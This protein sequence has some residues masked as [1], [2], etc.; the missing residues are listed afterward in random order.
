MNTNNKAVITCDLVNSS[1]YSSHERQSVNERI[2]QFSNKWQK[3]KQA[4]Y[5]FYRGDSL[6]GILEN[7]SEALRQALY[8]KSIIKSISLETSKRSTEADI[9]IS[10]GIGTIDYTGN[11]LLD[12][13][14]PAFQYS[15]RTLDTLKQKGRTIALTTSDSKQNK[16][17]DT[18]LLL[19]E[20][21]IKHWTI[22]SAEIIWRLIDGWSDKEIQKDLKI[23]Q[24]AVSQRKKNASWE[25]IEKTIL[26]YEE[27]FKKS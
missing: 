13:D 25:A 15:G 19:L 14:G 23:S 24:P 10:I 17:W 18:I 1:K 16:V 2:I 11:T 21:V 3:G 8:L 5:L 9:R 27:K 22:S 26:H 6:Q 20:E 12:S 4:E 7:P